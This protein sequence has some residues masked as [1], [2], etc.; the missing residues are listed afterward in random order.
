MSLI[1]YI[2]H[3]CFF[4]KWSFHSQLNESVKLHLTYSAPSYSMHKLQQEKDKVHV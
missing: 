3:V 2:D 4:L 1:G